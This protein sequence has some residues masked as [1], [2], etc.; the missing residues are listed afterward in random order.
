MIAG[1]VQVETLSPRHIG[2]YAS[3]NAAYG[4]S[5][6]SSQKAVSGSFTAG[7]DYF[8]AKEV[9]GLEVAVMEELLGY[10]V[11]LMTILGLVSLAAWFF[12]SVVM[13]LAKTR[14]GLTDRRYGVLVKENERL[15]SLLAEAEE[16][17]ARLREL[18]GYSRRI[19]HK[20]GVV[21]DAA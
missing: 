4:D 15:R 16:D 2:M 21:R 9:F 19:R 14:R 5:A 20:S 13:S 17:N 6:A 12:G 18:H 11:L 8:G 7:K 10:F 3:Q 1:E